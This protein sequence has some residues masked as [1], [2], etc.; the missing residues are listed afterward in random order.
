MDSKEKSP[1]G[2]QSVDRALTLLSLIAEHGGAGVA[3]PVLTGQTGL[4]R[5]TVRRILLAL[6]RAGYVEQS[7]D[8]DYFPGSECLVLG[9]AASRRHRLL[10]VSMDSLILLADESGDSSFVSVRRGS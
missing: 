6:I 3:M 1:G 10:D 7:A 8:G 4:S 5:P 9:A 2:S